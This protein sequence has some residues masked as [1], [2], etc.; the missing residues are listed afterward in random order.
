[1]LSPINEALAIMKSSDNVGESSRGRCDGDFPVSFS[2]LS[3]AFRRPRFGRVSGNNARRAKSS[4]GRTPSR[5]D[6]EAGS[7]IG[8]TCV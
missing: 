6:P 4:S 1:V 3:S 2:S 5:P 8:G 7:L